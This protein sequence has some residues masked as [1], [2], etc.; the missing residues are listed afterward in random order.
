ML[1]L[2]VDNDRAFTMCLACDKYM[3]FPNLL[4][5]MAT[6]NNSES[7]FYMEEGPSGI[8]RP[9]HSNKSQAHRRLAPTSLGWSNDRKLWFL[10]NCPR[11]VWWLVP[12]RTN[13]SFAL[14]KSYPQESSSVSRMLR[15]LDT[16]N[17]EW[18]RKKGRKIERKEEIHFNFL[19][20]ATAV[21]FTSSTSVSQ[22]M[23]AHKSKT[24]Y[25]GCWNP[26][27]HWDTVS[28]IFWLMMKS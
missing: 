15:N 23:D 8:N 4:P 28:R 25:D 6:E 21:P 27:K 26:P 1:I 24:F 7:S 12:C 3:R 22:A 16:R 19:E 2:I 5:I 14:I 18:K 17:R 10:I 13:G 11:N 20:I 9:P